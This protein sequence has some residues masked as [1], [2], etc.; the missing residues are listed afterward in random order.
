MSSG[1]NQPGRKKDGDLRIL[2]A[3]VGGIGDRGSLKDIKIANWINETRADVI[4]IGEVNVNWSRRRNT[5]PFYER[6]KTWC[7]DTEGRTI[8][9]TVAAHN[10]TD[11]EASEYQIGGIA[12][13]I[14]GQT[15]NRVIEWGSDESRLGRWIWVDLRGLQGLV[16]RIITAYRLVVTNNKGGSETVYS[17]HLRG[18]RLNGDTR[19]PLAAFDED[20]LSLV[21][22]TIEQRKQIVLMMD[23]NEDV[24][25]GTLAHRLRQFVLEESVSTTVSGPPPATHNR[26][27]KTIDGI[28]TTPTIATRTGGYQPF[29]TSPG[30]HRGIWIDADQMTLFGQRNPPPAKLSPRR[31]Q[32]SQAST[33][34]TY[35]KK[36][37]ALFLAT[38]L[39]ER[40]ERLKAKATYPATE[41]V[42]Q[43]YECL[44]NL[45]L[46]CIKEAE[47]T[48]RKLRMGN[49]PFSPAYSLNYKNI[50]ALTLL[51]KKHDGKRVSWKLIRRS[52]KDTSF[53]L[54]LSQFTADQTKSY[55]DESHQERRNIKDRRGEGNAAQFLREE[56]LSREAANE[57]TPKSR[58][59][60]YRSMRAREKTRM[61]SARIKRARQTFTPYG[62]TKIEVLNLEGEWEEKT[63]QEDIAQGF[64]KEAIKRGTQ[65]STTPFM[66]APLVD[67]FGY[68]PDT[69]AIDSVL[70]GSFVPPRG[71]DE[72]VLKMLP[73]FKL[74]DQTREASLLSTTIT[75]EEY[76]SSWKRLNEFTGVG[77]SGLH[78]GHF[79][80]M[81]KSPLS[82]EIYSSLAQIPFTS[83]FSPR[84]WR[85]CTDHMIQKDS[86]NF[87]VD[88]FRPINFMEADAN[89]NLKLMAKRAMAFGESNN[90]IAGEQYGSRKHHSAETQALN[91]RLTYDAW[92]LR[93]SAGV[94]CSND[95][96]SCYD[97]ILHVICAICLRRFGVDKGPISSMIEMLHFMTHKIHT[98]WGAAEGYGPDDNRFPLQGILQGNGAGPCI[99]LVISV[100]IFKMMKREGFGMRFHT[101][102][103]S[104]AVHVVGFAL[105]DDADLVV[106]EPD[107]NTSDD[108]TL[109]LAQKALDHWEGGVRCTGGAI[110]PAKSHWY[111]ISFKWKEGQWS[112]D[113]IDETKSL[114]VLNEFQ[115]RVE[116][117]QIPVSKA[118]KTLGVFLAPDG[119]NEDMLQYLIQKAQEWSEQM[120]VGQLGR[121][122]IW[123]AL[124]TTIMKTIEY[125]LLSTTLEEPELARLM[126][127]VL[128]HT[129]SQSGLPKTF[130]RALLFGPKSMQGMGLKDPF[131]TQNIKQLKAL[132]TYMDSPCITGQ[133][134]RQNWELMQL[135]MGIIKPIQE[136]S[137]AEVSCMITDCWLKRLWG[138]SEE[139]GVTIHHNGPHKPFLTREND[140][141]LMEVVVKGGWSREF[142][143]SFN[144][145]RLYL[146][147]LR[148]SDIITGSG[149]Q[150]R[151]S[152]WKGRREIQYERN[153]SWP[154]QGD[155][156]PQDWRHWK[157]ILRQLFE[158]QA[159]NREI[160]SYFW[161]GDEHSDKKWDW[162][163]KED[164]DRIY[165]K[166]NNQ[167]LIYSAVPQRRRLRKKLFGLSSATNDLSMLQHAKPCTVDLLPCNKVILTGYWEQFSP[168]SQDL[169]TTPIR[170]IIESMQGEEA[171]ALMNSIIGCEDELYLAESIKNESLFLCA[172]GSF[173]K[174]AGVG[175]ASFQLADP[176]HQFK[177]QCSF[178][179]PG[180]SKFQNAYR[181][182][183]SGLAGGIMA[184]SLLVEKYRID[185]GVIKIGCDNDAALDRIINDG[186][187]VTSSIKHFDLLRVASHY[188]DSCGKIKWIKTKVTGHA[189]EKQFGPRTFMEYLNIGC[190]QMAKDELKTVLTRDVQQFDPDLHH[191]GW[192]LKINKNKQIGDLDKDIYDFIQSKRTQKYWEDKAPNSRKGLQGKTDWNAI[193]GAAKQLSQKKLIWMVKHVSGHSAVGTVMKRRGE[194]LRSNC[195]RC[196]LP[197]ETI[198]HVIAC[199]DTDATDIW[200]EQLND[201]LQWLQRRG[202]KPQITNTIIA[203]LRTW[204]LDLPSLHM[205]D[206]RWDGIC[207]QE[208]NELGWFSFLQ[209]RL[210]LHWRIRQEAYYKTM[211]FRRTGRRWVEALIRKLWE[212]SWNMWDHRNK[213]L[214][215]KDRHKELGDNELGQMVRAEYDK[216]GRD[217]APRMKYLLAAA[218]EEV[219][220]YSVSRK[221]RWLRSVQAA[222]ELCARLRSQRD[223][224]QPMITGWLHHAH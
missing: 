107:A 167:L 204:R 125:P 196:G 224:A 29:S 33:V 18:L 9:H 81:H 136:I 149:K 123:R 187:K 57:D 176:A 56:W 212:I 221:K 39:R 16:T 110:V 70:E 7:T 14:R 182:E 163:Y 157:Q 160:P 131:I 73:H 152:V 35:H 169:S 96:K 77:P 155:P 52:W 144:R 86:N 202:T 99:W 223:P 59:S 4:G 175:T 148:F 50:K 130:P 22:A 43:E 31:L 217:L 158:L 36:L 60:K 117:K 178:R 53:N 72:Y 41:E 98:A 54:P 82:A 133:L 63:T 164:E 145:C 114:T 198:Q 19:E 200:N 128:R 115:E 165:Q 179:T 91:K 95:A 23:V 143:L 147:A 1:G 51:Q 46:Q 153:K 162:M 75:K 203:G 111:N 222:R 55:L 140:K 119:N 180:F 159:D 27:S 183:L 173:L 118:K 108:S 106:S 32:S 142:I 191:T 193:G 218:L 49:T 65:T 12:M 15:V 101:P 103:T 38:K 45:R 174:E 3:N 62:V 28:F 34:A 40:T 220:E 172:D 67:S 161:L 20:L 78:F 121:D 90:L 146:Q 102:I 8:L 168:I 24:R 74:P 94:L 71:T 13:M 76:A 6:A 116:L 5:R 64:I 10:E 80:V 177:W 88:R 166:R 190:D 184:V 171:W 68:S 11:P 211:G 17:Q 139:G 126:K 207:L 186:W 127:V 197:D 156:S 44:D 194:R 141:F 113:E 83:G 151:Q 69:P 66:T 154:N 85:S 201:L 219:L 199:K 21:K 134:L 188:L 189:D 170:D 137:F 135:E 47:S 89:F 122:E 216:G 208:Q 37:E 58:Q 97:R 120:R 129:L 42:R 61:E 215:D 109:L 104:E 185:S 192:S 209:G 150:I 213:V 92:R 206:R 181:C 138:A 105:V 132:L 210:S 195:P 79:K 112:Y 30:D 87:H 84:R 205:N 25:S 2:Y 214:H 26:G 93:K 48:C 100:V 124:Q